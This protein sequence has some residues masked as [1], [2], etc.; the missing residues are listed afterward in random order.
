MKIKPLLIGLAVVAVLIGLRFAIT[1]LQDGNSATVA[2]S[3]QAKPGSGDAVESGGGWQEP[4][5]IKENPLKR[6]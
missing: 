5:S 4:P 6:T 1:K 2:T 3:T